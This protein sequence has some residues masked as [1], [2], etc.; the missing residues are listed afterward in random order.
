MN[1][2][3][4]L[5]EDEI[6]LVELA[7]TFW[8]G[9]RMI[10][11]VMGV[12]LLAASMYLNVVDRKYTVSMVLKSAQEPS[13]S[14]NISGLGGIASL[15]GIE[16]PSGS[17]A[18]FSS[19]PL[20]MKSREVAEAIF[21]DE[22]L[23]QSIFWS[24]WD[25]EEEEWRAPSRS[26]L[27]A[28][29]SPVKAAVTGSPT[30]DYVP[31]NAARLSEVIEKQISASIDSKSDLLNVSTEGSDPDVALN[32]MNRVVYETDALFRERFIKAGSAALE[33]YKGQLSRAQSGEHREALAQ[34]IVKEEQKL[35]LAT[36]SSSYVAE[37]LR[38]PDVSRMPT[39]PK[40]TLILALSVV[41]GL[42][43]GAGLV[44]LRSVLANQRSS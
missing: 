6:D 20:L 41:L 14:S 12:M 22:L 17:N 15:A 23:I 43:A 30:T 39:S 19:F 16:L 26:F 44:L 31:P 33:F 18:D 8:R 3:N 21:D 10:A 5:A 37:V 2:T 40:P 29:L 27:K 34:L 11:A 4:H 25:A 42:F 35:M 32:L 38:G 13:Q 9:R 24:E 7:K 36:R 1:E 28:V